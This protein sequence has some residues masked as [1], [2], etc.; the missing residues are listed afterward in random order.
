MSYPSSLLKGTA[1]CLT[2]LLERQTGAPGTGAPGTHRHVTSAGPPGWL[3]LKTTCSVGNKG[4]I[5]TVKEEFQGNV[6]DQA[7]GSSAGWGCTWEPSNPAGA[8]KNEKEEG[9][10]GGGVTRAQ[11]SRV[12]GM[13][14]AE[15]G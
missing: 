12:D 9:L 15:A 13:Q 2:G 5:Q 7:E 11:A 6:I 4:K 8:V 10:P 3:I 1:V 14:A